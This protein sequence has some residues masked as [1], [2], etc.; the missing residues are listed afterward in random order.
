MPRKSEP[1]L[2]NRVRELR[3]DVAAMTQ[4]QLADAVGV[5]RQTIVAL[6]KGA[7]TPSLALAIRIAR[8]FNEPTDTVFY[9]D[10]T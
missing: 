7:Y 8:L 6:E 1:H 4:Q 5:T 10:E 9:L 3:S 2:Q